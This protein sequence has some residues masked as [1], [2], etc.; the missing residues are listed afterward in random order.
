[1][2]VKLYTVK[3]EV[4]GDISLPKEYNLKTS[5]SLLLQAVRVYEDRT[6][7]GLARVKTRSEINKTRKKLY[8]QK[9]TGG[10]RHGAKSAHIFVGGGVA[11]GPKGEKRDLILPLK[12]KRKAL[13]LSL[14]KKF[15]LKTAILVEG[16]NKVS[17]TSEANKMIKTLKDNFKI[18][19]KVV[20]VFSKEN[21]KSAKYFKNI[22]NVL[23][24]DFPSLN[25]F[26]V[27]TSN[28]MFM[29][30]SIFKSK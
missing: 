23:V 18:K 6:H 8:K 22:K 1:M 4:K 2:K 21:Y 13:Y 16:L 5:N 9:G 10:A 15:N 3:G 27:L 7:F 17:K 29:D 12:M 19:S 24:N 11:H 26:S 25:A 30:S 14:I 28:I 20:I